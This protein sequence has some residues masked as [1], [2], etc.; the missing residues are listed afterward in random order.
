M[1]DMDGF[2]I[3]TTMWHLQ[4]ENQSELTHG[5]KFLLSLVSS[6]TWVLLHTSKWGI[7]PYFTTK[8]N[9]ALFVLCDK[10]RQFSD[11]F[12]LECQNK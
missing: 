1:A 7:K 2:K 11:V 6:D 9:F 10:E 4:N 12:V 8:P 5:L 3:F